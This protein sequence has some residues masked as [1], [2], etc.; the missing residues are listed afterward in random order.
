[1]TR[2]VGLALIGIGFCAPIANASGS[3]DLIL[4][5][6]Q[7]T[8]S[9]TCDGHTQIQVLGNQNKVTLTGECEHIEIAGNQN[10]VTIEGAGSISVPGND[11]I[12]SWERGIDGKPPAVSNPGSRNHLARVKKPR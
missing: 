3:E 11:N 7:R 9:R 2:L 6:N 8:V 10:I 5:E 12:V 4:L 1:M